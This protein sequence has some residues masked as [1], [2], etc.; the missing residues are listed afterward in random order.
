MHTGF[1]Q[2]ECTNFATAYN[3]LVAAT[4]SAVYPTP[5]LCTSNACNGQVMLMHSG[6]GSAAASFAALAALAAAAL[7]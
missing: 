3:A 1:T 6:A 7:L 4:P 5:V 2:A